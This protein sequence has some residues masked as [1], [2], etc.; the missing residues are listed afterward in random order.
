MKAHSRG[1]RVVNRVRLLRNGQSRLGGAHMRFPSI[2]AQFKTT[3][4]EDLGLPLLPEN[5]EN[6][7]SHLFNLP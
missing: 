6:T 7:I 3:S 1:R 5:Q 2:C 4:S